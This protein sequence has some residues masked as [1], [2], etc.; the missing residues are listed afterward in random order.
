MTLRAFDKAASHLEAVVLNTNNADDDARATQ[1]LNDL[2]QT[3]HLWPLTF[4]EENVFEGNSSK[5]RAQRETE[6]RDQFFNISRLMDCVGCERC[7]LWGKLQLN[8]IGTALRILYAPDTDLVL[9]SLRRNQLVAFLNLLHNLSLSLHYTAILQPL[10]SYS[11]PNSH[12]TL[13]DSFAR[14]LGF[15]GFDGDEVDV[16]DLQSMLFTGRAA[17]SAHSVPKQ[18]L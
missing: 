5:T 11:T 1:L 18:E 16:E 6:F 7:R 9:R 3:R 17:T 4:D 2:L 8:G 12:S 13:S 14:N 10:L 15:S